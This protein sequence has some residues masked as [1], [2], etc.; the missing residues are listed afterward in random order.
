MSELWWVKRL[1]VVAVVLMA[2]LNWVAYFDIR[3]PS[4]TTKMLDFRPFGYSYEDATA[5]SYALQFTSMDAHR[6]VYIP[7]DFTFIACLTVLVIMIA[8][9]F[10]PL[11]FWW[12]PIP[13][14]LAFAAADIVENLMMIQIFA[15][16]ALDE[17]VVA[18]ASTATQMKFASL[19]FA[20]LSAFSLWQMKR[21]AT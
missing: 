20:A 2:A 9:L 16:K 21:S 8:R 19:A 4:D 14:V 10:K 7:L 1:S 6:D 5:F 15:R 3:L 11:R 13:F 12:L 17:Q 18:L